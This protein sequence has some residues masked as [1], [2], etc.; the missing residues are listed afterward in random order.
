MRK[1]LYLYIVAGIIILTGF[2]LYTSTQKI[3]EQPEVNIVAINKITKQAASCWDNLELLDH[4]E[5][6]Y[7]FVVI[8]N[9]ENICYTSDE[10]L[11]N[12]PQASLRQ[13]FLSADIIVKTSV[14]GKA[15]VETYP[16]D[17]IKQAQR[18][19]SAATAVVFGLLSALIISTLLIIN[20]NAVRPFIRLERF[21]H[22]IS[23]GNFNEPLPIDKNNSFGLFTHSL[24]I[25]RASLL[26]ARQKQLAAERA[27]KEHIASLNHDI[28]TPITSIK[29]TSELL[30]A[31]SNDATLME[32]LKVIDIKAD[33]V[34]RLMDDMLQSTLEELEEHSINLA[35]HPSNV[36]LRVFENANN[37]YSMQIDDIPPCLLELDI[38]RIE[39]V[40]G[41]IV[42]N[43]Y[44]YAATD[45]SVLF[46]MRGDFLQV[47]IN[48]FGGGVDP[49]ELELICTKFY[50][51]ESAKAL[52]KEGEG[53][54]LY[55]AKQL[56][57]KMG[58][59]L[60]AIN[61]DGGFTIRLWIKLSR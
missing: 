49:D 61:R 58:G 4:M 46:K 26:E 51:G 55:I 53:L 37:L 5:F 56:M 8:D 47:D 43:S 14:V 29:L 39:Q 2:L 19:L 27:K 13:G 18:N 33:Q 34:S 42:T 30:Q 60:E 17:N 11:P 25:M 44:K 23:T 10:G 24:D 21:A 59:G 7:R 16:D 15:L 28:K 40:V 12:S 38:S 1:Y 48:D 54:G 3:P 22:K 35:S 20:N 9:A 31:S 52:Q 36:L 6:E 57:V 41:N 32:K 45:I 50:R